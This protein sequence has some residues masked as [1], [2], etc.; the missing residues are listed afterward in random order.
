MFIGANAVI[1]PGVTIG[2]G[3]VIG[4]GAVVSRSI[5][6]GVVTAGV[7]AKTIK[8]VADYWE[9]VKD[10]AV[11]TAGMSEVAKR[12]LLFR[13]FGRCSVHHRVAAKITK[14]ENARLP[15]VAG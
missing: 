7:P 4:A 2:S 15:R 11:S 14:L 5:P 8:T 13:H 12:V 6:E 10:R 3:S 1:L 9:G